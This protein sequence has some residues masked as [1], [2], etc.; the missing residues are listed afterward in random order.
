MNRTFN[1]YST[2]TNADGTSRRVESTIG[3]VMDSFDTL[4]EA[5]FEV[6]KATSDCP[7]MHWEKTKFLDFRQ[8]VRKGEILHL[9][10][11]SDSC[12]VFTGHYL[13]A[14]RF[15][16][17]NVYQS[18]RCQMMM[19]IYGPLVTEEAELINFCHSHLFGE[20]KVVAKIQK[21]RDSLFTSVANAFQKSLGR[22]VDAD[23]LVFKCGI[24]HIL[25]DFV[26]LAESIFDSEGGALRS[27]PGFEK[28]PKNL[29]KP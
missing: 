13:D 22:P 17:P 10:H 14:D 27:N 5:I 21:L 29:F 24:G 26:G 3:R 2:E 20:N 7:F 1:V 23:S 4:L 16:T 12:E 9:K 11:K 18:Y 25:P 15:A 28:K 19:R 8:G 6:S